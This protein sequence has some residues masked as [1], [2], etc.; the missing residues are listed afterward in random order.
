MTKEFSK[1]GG[2]LST[3]QAKAIES[4]GD[5][6]TRVSTIWEGFQNQLTAAVAG[7]FKAFLDTV[8]EGVVKMGGIG[9]VARIAGSYIVSAFQGGLSFI[10]GFLT[11]LDY[12]IIKIEQIARL[13]LRINQ[14]ATLGLSNVLSN[15]G[16]KIAAL[17]K[18]INARQDAASAGT[19]L[20]SRVNQGLTSL[21]SKISQSATENTQASKVEV[22]INADEGLSAKVAQSTAINT[23]VIKLVRSIVAQSA[24]SVGK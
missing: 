22:I 21:Q 4:Y 12:V 20:S 16:E 7:P 10:G 6:I 8:S 23:Q 3:K 14:F 15:S 9:E 24:S 13:M 5:S 2:E 1:F 18:D 11:A 17:T 19:N